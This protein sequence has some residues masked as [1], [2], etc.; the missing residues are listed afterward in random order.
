LVSKYI[1]V[2]GSR[3]LKPRITA[4]VKALNGA[5]YEAQS[6]FDCIKGL[7]KELSIKAAIND[8][9]EY[10]EWGEQAKIHVIWDGYSI[11][12][13]GDI[14]SA[15]ALGCKVVIIYAP[16]Y[17]NPGHK[18][19]VELVEELRKRSAK[20]RLRYLPQIEAAGLGDGA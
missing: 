18:I 8:E 7:R 16:A 2:I 19:D 6:V 10:V 1:L 5:G 9:L 15:L 4:Y 13:Y 20:A 17:Y 3:S 14:C 12:T 11:G